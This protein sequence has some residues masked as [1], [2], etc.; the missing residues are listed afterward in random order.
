MPAKPTA[1][2]EKAPVKVVFADNQH[3]FIE[4]F[5]QYLKQFP[6]LHVG[7]YR[8]NGE[9]LLELVERE[10]PDIVFTD[11]SM[12]KKNGIEAAKEIK[13][14]YAHIK[15]IALTSLHD[16]EHI[17]GMLAAGACGY[18]L[19]EDEP[20]IIAD[21]IEKALRG[22][23]CYSPAIANRILKLVQQS[24][25]QQAEAVETKPLTAKETAVLKSF[26][27]VYTNKAIASDLGMKPTA[28]RAAKKRIADKTGCSHTVELVFYALRTAVASL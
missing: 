3:F 6:H 21:A 24:K 22:E 7:G 17:T 19:K 10:K 14:K 13:A 2:T 25:L 16:D 15:L 4:G 23:L 8:R 28:V 12:P 5:V 27:K 9:E 20:H 11:I 26:C 1:H 18:L